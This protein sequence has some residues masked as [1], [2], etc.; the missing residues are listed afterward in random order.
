MSFT[1]PPADFPPPPNDPQPLL[2]A[3]DLQAVSIGSVMVALTELNL[4]VSTEDLLKVI[5]DQEEAG[6][7]EQ[8]AEE[9]QHHAA[10]SK[11][12]SAPTPSPVL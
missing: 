3:R 5:H 2:P 10:P 6:L 12:K 9:A 11:C 7:A 8:A 4:K 1:H